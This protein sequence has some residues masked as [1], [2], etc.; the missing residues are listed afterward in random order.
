[1]YTYIGISYLSRETGTRVR[2][3]ASV[4]SAF[5]DRGRIV[6]RLSICARAI[7]TRVCAVHGIDNMKSLLWCQPEIDRACIEVSLY[8]SARASLFCAY[9][10]YSSLSSICIAGK[11]KKKDDEY[12]GD[13]AE[14]RVLF[15]LRERVPERERER[16]GSNLNLSL[17]ARVESFYFFAKTKSTRGRNGVS[18]CYTGKHVSFFFFSFVKI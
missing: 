5:V 14:T 4:I 16:E 6:C 11:R 1:M 12:T 8:V 10:L 9:I 18:R 17:N 13:I 3:Y 15:K 7:Y 2:V